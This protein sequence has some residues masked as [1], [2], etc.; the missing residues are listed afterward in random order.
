MKK[1]ILYLMIGLPGAGKSTYTKR[2]TDAMIASADE[3]R[4]EWFGDAG[5]QYTTEF[6]NAHGIDPE[7]MTEP[8]RNKAANI[9]IWDEVFRRTEDWL[10]EGKNVVIDGINVLRSVRTN[11]IRQFCESAFIIGVWVTTDLETCLRRDGSRSRTVG[12]ENLRRIAAQFR[13]PKL[14]EGFDILEE[15]DKDG[16]L[17]KR[18]ARPG[19]PENLGL[20]PGEEPAYRQ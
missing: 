4:R 18:T 9:I 19:I 14:E 8:E 13:K 1:P 15:R 7:R 5:L 10:S 2:R 17:L 6:L 16:R 20:L 3:V 11:M 12:E